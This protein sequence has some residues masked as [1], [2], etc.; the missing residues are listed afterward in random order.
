MKIIHIPATPEAAD[1][2]LGDIGSIVTAR[3]WE[4]AAII[5]ARVRLADGPGGNV[6]SDNA[7]LT[8]TQFAALGITGLRSHNT[9]QRHVQN[10]LDANDDQYPELGADIVMPEKD[11]PSNSRTTDP[12]PGSQKVD[13][14][15][16]NPKAT[17]KAL[18]DDGFVDRVLDRMDDETID[19]VTETITRRREVD[20][21]VA[22]VENG[23]QPLDMDKYSKPSGG[24]IDSIAD[25]AR[26]GANVERALDSVMDAIREYGSIGADTAL[27]DKIKTTAMEMMDAIVQVEAT[28]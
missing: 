7:H 14:I 12:E 11:Y 6:T 16:S 25:Q 26:L 17:A 22:A 15:M 20:R 3:E 27:A 28:S 2:R 4:R 1:L 10:W 21:E 18:T 9:I 19:R 23:A 13:D 24:M 5:A 8:P